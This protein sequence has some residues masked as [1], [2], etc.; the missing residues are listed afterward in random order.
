MLRIEIKTPIMESCL[1][2]GIEKISECIQIDVQGLFSL[3]ETMRALL[4]LKAKGLESLMSDLAELCEGFRITKNSATLI[5]KDHP[6][7]IAPNLLKAGGIITKI[8]IEERKIVWS[9]VCDDESLLRIFEALENAG[10]E[11]EIVYK[12]KFESKESLTLREEE[13]LKI[14]F[15][16]GFFDYPKKI[17]LEELA[18]ILDLAPSTLS[19]ILRSAQRKVLRR[20]FGEEFRE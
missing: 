3:D 8:S 6:C 2:K 20:Y 9:I 1:F 7:L 4:K 12:G 16:K 18:K 19:E 11:H 5:L 14:A 15:E 17:K 10:I 13:I